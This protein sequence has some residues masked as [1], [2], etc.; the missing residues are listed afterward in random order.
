MSSGRYPEAICGNTEPTP[1]IDLAKLKKRNNELLEKNYHEER[2]YLGGKSPQLGL[3]LSGGGTRSASFSIGVMKALQENGIMDKVDVVSSVS[4]GSYA[5]YWY[6]MQNFYLNRDKLLEPGD[7]KLSSDIDYKLYMTTKAEFDA[8]RNATAERLPKKTSDL[9]FADLEYCKDWAQQRPGGEIL[10]NISDSEQYKFQYTLQESSKILSLDKKPGFTHTLRNGSQYV[11]NTGAQILS[12]PFHWVFNGLAL[13]WN[14]NW[15]PYRHFYQNG[16]ERTYGYVPLKYDLREFANDDKVWGFPRVNAKDVNMLDMQYFLSGIKDNKKK[17]PYFIINATADYSSY[18]QQSDKK[19][20][21]KSVYEFTPWRCGSGLTGYVTADKC[22]A[23]ISM[24]RAVSISGAALDGLHESIDIDGNS[25]GKTNA[26][27]GILNVFNL[28]IGY[29][30]QNHDPS[31]SGVGNFLYN[32]IPFPLY[33]LADWTVG[34]QVNDILLSDG[35]HIE[36]LGI[37]SLVRRGV[38]TI[39]AV[40]GEQDGSSSFSSLK[41]LKQNLRKEMGMDIVWTDPADDVRFNPPKNGVISAKIK[42]YVDDTGNP[43]DIDLYYVK[44]SY[45]KDGLQTTNDPCEDEYPYTVVTYATKNDKFPHE[46]TADISYDAAQF[47]AYR[48]LGYT[49]GWHFPKEKLEESL[50]NFSQGEK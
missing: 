6:F 16:L 19:E 36:N 23:D 21:L 25:E 42:G 41:R 45:K 18:I 13:N 4:G 14:A 34:K 46:S 37:F 50:K 7:S 31:A 22:P 28:D 40:D 48:D 15:S 35:G 17:L 11:I 3:A 32:F 43:K 20:L 1:S 44:L 9:L 5:A 8:Q 10:N 26:L 29:K 2:K 24:G 39:I 47:K 49:I 12:I 33:F 38:T 27:S 30:I